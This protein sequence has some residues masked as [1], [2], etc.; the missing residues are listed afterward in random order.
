MHPY[1]I[2]DQAFSALV[3]LF[4]EYL[5]SRGIEVEVVRDQYVCDPGPGITYGAADEYEWTRDDPSITVPS[6]PTIVRNHHEEFMTW[7]RSDK[8]DP[9]AKA[10]LKSSCKLD[11]LRTEVSWDGKHLI[12]VG[13]R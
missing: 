6:D 4:K 2:N 12:F 10:T 5:Q 8:P 9:A 11:T 1:A 7:L 13:G 3:T